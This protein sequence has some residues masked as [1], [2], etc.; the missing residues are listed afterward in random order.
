MWLSVLVV[1]FF[2]Y[3]RVIV[4]SSVKIAD[5]GFSSLSAPVST[6]DLLLAIAR[7]GMYPGEKGTQTNTTNTDKEV[8]MPHLDYLNGLPNVD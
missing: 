4:M 6:T 1:L 2:I 7:F 5:E 3:F 8:P